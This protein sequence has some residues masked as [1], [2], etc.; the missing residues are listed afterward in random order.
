[1]KFSVL[2]LVPSYRQDSPFLTPKGKNK[3]NTM[4]F[5]NNYKELKLLE[6]NK[7]GQLTSPSSILI[8]TGDK[9]TNYRQN[10]SNTRKNNKIR[11]GMVKGKQDQ[12]Q[13][14]LSNLKTPPKTT[15]KKTQLLQSQMV[16]GIG[17]QVTNN[18][19]NRLERSKK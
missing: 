5:D 18:F 19:R 8:T 15:T 17:L 12:Q 10:G 11:K 4:R 6:S 1:M 16:L 13:Q 2:I 7:T 14:M 3:G 9:G